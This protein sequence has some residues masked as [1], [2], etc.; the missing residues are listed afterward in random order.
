[1][2]DA[3]LPADADANQNV[4]DL[5]NLLN[6]NQNEN[7]NEK[8]KTHKITLPTISFKPE[9][10]TWWRLMLSI[11]GAIKIK[12]QIVALVKANPNPDKS[13][14]QIDAADPP[15]TEKQ[16]KQYDQLELSFSSEVLR[17]D[18][19]TLVDAGVGEEDPSVSMLDAIRKLR[20]KWGLRKGLDANSLYSKLT[21]TCFDLKLGKTPEKFEKWASGVHRKAG[22][23]PEFIV[24]PNGHMVHAFR[25]LLDPS[26]FN[27]MRGFRKADTPDTSGPEGWQKWCTEVMDWI[28]TGGE[29]ANAPEKQSTKVNAN[30]AQTSTHHHNPNNRHHPHQPDDFYEVDA[31]YGYTGGASSSNALNNGMWCVV[32]KSSSHNTDRCYDVLRAKGKKKGKGKGGKGGKKGTKKVGK[33]GNGGGGGG[34]GKGG[35]GGGN[36]KGG[37]GGGKKGVKKHY[38]NNN[39]GSGGGGWGYAW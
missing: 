19:F 21:S 22:T 3:D 37:K 1:M 13:Y 35:K 26:M 23:I 11:F 33:G 27:L 2:V 9:F 25:Y 10:E 31:N 20:S 36:G 38:N 8:D 17:D 18:A 12:P 29:S 14:P 30:A 15:L 6:Q 5:L 34:N 24:S 16:T 28:A 32:C 4:N 7:Q 39:W